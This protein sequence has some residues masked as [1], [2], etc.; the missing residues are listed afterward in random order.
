MANTEG[1]YNFSG[2]KLEKISQKALTIYTT[3]SIFQDGN[4]IDLLIRASIKQQKIFF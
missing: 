1:H 4:L 2:A 3:I